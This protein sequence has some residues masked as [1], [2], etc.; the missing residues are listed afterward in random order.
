MNLFKIWKKG[1]GIPD[2]AP[3]AAVAPPA[4][5]P[6]N[7]LI[8]KIEPVYREWQRRIM[9]MTTELDTVSKETENE[10][11]AIGESLQSFSR[12]CSE[13]SS[14][15]S[16]V[17]KMLDGGGGF[18]ADR[19]KSLIG[20]AHHKVESCAAAISNGISGMDDLKSRTDSILELKEFLKKLAHSISVLGTLMKIETARVGEDE[21]NIM[22][23]IVDELSQEIERENEEIAVST[24]TA[25]LSLISSGEKMS[26]EIKKFNKDLVANRERIKNILEELDKMIMQSK[27]ACERIENRASQF[28]PEVGKVVSAL[29]YHD[30]CRQQMEHIS[31]S[32]EEISGKITSLSMMPPE[33][34]ILFNKW[35][36][37]ALRIQILQLE[38]VIAETAASAQDISSHLSRIS[39]LAGAQTEDARL[40]LEEDETGSRRI[41]KISQ[42]FEA[43]SNMLSKSETMIVDMNN[44]I[45]GATGIIGNM[46]KQVL[47]IEMISENINLL[48]LN[49]IV[50]VARTGDSGRGLEVL[51]GEIR[52]LSINAKNEITRGSETIK[53]ILNIS[54]NFKKTL[55]DELAA[56]LASTDEMLQQTKDAIKELLSTDESL[57]ESIN[58]ISG[59]TKNLESE[60]FRLISGIK[61]GEIIKTRMGKIVSELRSLL[62]ELDKIVPVGG[63]GLDFTSPE[64]KELEKRYTMHSERKV[65][66]AALTSISGTGSRTSGD[67]IAAANDDL[68][69]NV[70]LF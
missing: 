22:T 47:N 35:A 13:N 17:V 58:E 36:V 7:N 18:N 45:S 16:S 15:A 5:D 21:F 4:E 26:S 64:L 51:A 19:F 32:L 54:A 37:N 69:D 34:K 66:E 24:K 27:L 55:S 42:E 12:G 3:A 11:L 1:N 60:I 65:H 52:K 2:D 62:S 8:N 46:S 10:F 41:A 29:Q 39:G 48:A 67:K 57:M 6:L 49:T 56:V 25:R 44:A 30:I 50:K 23:S 38:N 43:L 33:E 70:E 14:S 63:D 53:D 40:I 9:E 68:G 59:N 61:F 31:D 20:H 28:P